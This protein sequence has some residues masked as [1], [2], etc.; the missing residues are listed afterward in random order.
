MNNSISVN[1]QNANIA[2]ENTTKN[3][4]GIKEKVNMEATNKK[5]ILSQIQQEIMQK[6]NNSNNN[7]NNQNNFL[8]KQTKKKLS[9]E[10]NQIQI[11]N[12]QTKKIENL[13]GSILVD[14]QKKDINEEFKGN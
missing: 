13:R 10:T 7:N 1:Y 5:N 3:L 12:L 2:N 14:N 4:S 8:N 6:V 11:N 9:L